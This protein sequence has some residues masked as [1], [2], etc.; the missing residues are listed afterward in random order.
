[1]LPGLFLFL[2]CK[3]FLEIDAPKTQVTSALIFE[4]DQAAISA[5]VGLYSEMSRINLAMSNGGQTIYAG[6]AADEIATTSPNEDLD[7]FYLNSIPATNTTGLSRLWN[8]GYRIIYHAN[9]VLEGIEK[10]GTLTDSIARML[11]GEM[12]LGRAF[13]YFNL[14]NLFGDVPLQLTTDY[15]TNSK[16]ART[17]KAVVYDQLVNDLTAAKD[18][19]PATYASANRARPNRWTA[20]ALLSRV[21]LYKQEW[22]K[23]AN[24]ASEVIQSG[25]YQ[26]NG[27]LNSVFLPASTETIWQLIRDNNNTAEGASFI[28]ASATVKP[29]YALTPQLLSVFSPADLR[30]SSWT[31][32]NIVGGQPYVYPYKYKVRL[33]TPIS[34]YYVVLRLAELY[35]IRAEARLELDDISGAQADINLI[36]QRAGLNPTSVTDKNGLLFILEQERQAE[37]FTEWGHRWFDLKRRG[38]ADAVLAIVKA[39]NWQST[40][41]L[42][43]IPQ[44]ELLTNPFLVQNPGY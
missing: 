38:R 23:A 12:L 9:A 3:K 5:T 36:R 37:Y 19:L 29:T 14:V 1:M 4:N 35:L 15:E 28:P 8:Q 26:L 21:Y 44:A 41:Q 34:E 30:K 25:A 43:P 31:K 20:V 17:A 24:A 39:P 10:G 27:N 32:Q 22:E 7:V 33:S 11:K 2:S 18:L 40:D 13:H 42:F 6:L 16:K